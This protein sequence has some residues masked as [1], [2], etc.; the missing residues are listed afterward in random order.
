MAGGKPKRPSRTNHASVPS[1]LERVS[2]EDDRFT[3]KYCIPV[4]SNGNDLELLDASGGEL[5]H[6]KNED[7]APESE[8]GTNSSSMIECWTP[9]AQKFTGKPN[10]N[11]NLVITCRKVLKNNDQPNTDEEEPHTRNRKTRSQSGTAKEVVYCEPDDSEQDEKESSFKHKRMRMTTKMWINEQVQEENKGKGRQR[12]AAQKQTETKS[13]TTRKP[14]RAKTVSS[15]RESELNWEEEFQPEKSKRKKRAET[16]VWPQDPLPLEEDLPKFPNT[17]K[18]EWSFEEKSRKVL[19]KFLTD[20]IDDEDRNFLLQMMERTDIALV[21]EGLYK[22]KHQKCWDLE[23]IKHRAGNQISHRIRRFKLVKRTAADFFKSRFDKNPKEGE[24]G[25]EAESFVTPMELNQDTSMRI[26]DYINYIEAWEKQSQIGFE[27][28]KD[29]TFRT[30]S[31]DLYDLSQDRLYLIDFDFKKMLPE[32]Y[33]SFKN[34][35]MLPEVL[36]G[37]EY[38]LMRSVTP[39]AQPFMGPNLYLTPPGSYTHFHQD[40]HGTV[41]SGHLCLKGYN[42]V[43]ML[44]RMDEGRKQHA[45][46]LLTGDDR[47][48]KAINFDGLYGL[49]HDDGAK[50]EWPDYEAIRNCKNMNY[51]PCVFILE[52]GQLLH[53]GKGRLHAFRKMTCDPLEPSDCHCDIRKEIIQQR[54]ICHDPLCFSIAWDWMFMG[55][56]Q[57]GMKNEVQVVLDC[58][59]LAFQNSVRSLATPDFCLVEMAKEELARLESLPVE[60]RYTSKSF[61]NLMGIGPFV[62]ST[63]RSQIKRIRDVRDIRRSGVQIFDIPDAQKKDSSIDAY[64][65]DYFCKI[66]Q[67]ELSNIYFHCE[68]CENLLA[69]DFNVCPD[70]YDNRSKIDVHFQMHPHRPISATKGRRADY[71]HLG[72]SRRDYKR[73][74]GCKNGPPCSTCDYM[75]CCSCKCHKE[76]SMRLRLNSVQDLSKLLKGVQRYCTGNI[77]ID[78]QSRS[79]S[80]HDNISLCAESVDESD[81]VVEQNNNPCNNQK[82]INNLTTGDLTNDKGIEVLEIADS[83]EM[84]NDDKRRRSVVTDVHYVST[85]PDRSP[86]HVPASPPESV[87]ES[88]PATSRILCPNFF[89]D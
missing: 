49:P 18:C 77:S 37:G 22:E 30:S 74:C 21:S 68:G 14:R 75:I 19:A 7:N 16:I 55:C 48:R 32:S 11:G 47:R 10:K 52:P 67:R 40:G 58:E 57:E 83:P 27:D 6:D 62:L 71:N 28:N 2:D 38:C 33:E 79:E 60:E 82:T 78:E 85:S 39:E 76:Y 70:C 5:N 69:K 84:P 17:G 31:R 25:N 65:N 80:N 3:S 81:D 43:V 12:K 1:Q 53:I 56:T 29:N 50:P 59:K 42:E 35:F 88:N 4:K 61:E 46:H 15:Y 8:D 20:D 24:I 64:G 41:D 26:S 86:K 36:P 54:N 72:G 34:N 23:Y 13:S 9:T 45:L 66:C 73:A 63:L 89:D 44:R 51:Y 87:Q